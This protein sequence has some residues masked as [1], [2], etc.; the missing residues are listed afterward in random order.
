MAVI[1]SFAICNTELVNPA[2]AANYGMF[3][4]AASSEYVN[5]KDAVL[6]EEFKNSDNVKEGLKTLQQLQQTVSRIKNELQ[7]NSQLDI[8]PTIDS[9]LNI[10]KVRDGLNKVIL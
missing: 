5:P 3:G 8:I 4:S 2:L 7:Q 6:N 1:S 9:D 10:G